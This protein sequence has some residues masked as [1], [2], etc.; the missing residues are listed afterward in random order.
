MPEEENKALDRI[1]AQIEKTFEKE[2]A[3][4]RRY[5]NVAAIDVTNDQA[6][7]C[8]LR[9]VDGLPSSEVKAF[10]LRKDDMAEL[11]LWL[12]EKNPQMV[13]IEDTGSLWES[14]LR[15]LREAGLE[16]SL[17]TTDGVYAEQNLRSSVSRAH[18]LA[19]AV[20]S[21]LLGP[22]KVKDKKFN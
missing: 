7:A 12:K 1:M 20:R 22:V 5:H 11:A 9:T 8:W 16:V 4:Q 14:P 3:S 10:G 21:S 6:T 15:L 18:W 2:L 13:V 19:A 17:V